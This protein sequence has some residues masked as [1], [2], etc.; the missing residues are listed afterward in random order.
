MP[1]TT[2]RRG[3][4]TGAALRRLIPAL[5]VTAILAFS[6]LA[7]VPS[8][9]SM[10]DAGYWYGNNCGVKGSGY[11]DHGKLCPNRPFPGKGVDKSSVSDNTGSKVSSDSTVAAITAATSSDKATTIATEDAQSA[12]QSHGKGKGHGHGNGHVKGK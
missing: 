8:V 5:A 12:G 3:L 1:K 6:Y 9:A 2:S 4:G 10:R 7:Q 11:H